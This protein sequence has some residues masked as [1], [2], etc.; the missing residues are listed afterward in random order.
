M[1]GLADG[2]F[3]LPYTIDDYLAD[4]IMTPKIDT[5]APEFDEAEKAV[6]DVWK[7][8]TILKVKPVD[9]FHKKL[10]HLCGIMWEWRETRKV[11]KKAIEMI[12]EIREEFW[13]DVRIPGEMN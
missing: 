9:N 6:N 11:L 3:I 8:S 13:K 5:N 1:Q 10:G 12:K 7:N 4:E 2:Y